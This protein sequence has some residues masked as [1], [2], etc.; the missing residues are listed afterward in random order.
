MHTR[1]INR[2]IPI[3]SR[4]GI[5]AAVLCLAA[6][7]AVAP[8]AMAETFTVDTTDDG[9]GADEVGMR[10]FRWA[11][12][13]ANDNGTGLDTI[14][15]DSSLTDEVDEDNVLQIILTSTPM[16]IESELRIEAPVI[17]VGGGDPDE[18]VFVDIVRTL[19]EDETFE[20]TENITLANASLRTTSVVVN[21]GN[22]NGGKKIDIVYEISPLTTY[23]ITFNLV[24][25]DLDHRVDG[26]ARLVK[27]GLG[28]LA[29]LPS[30]VDYGGGTLLVDGV[31]RVDTD[32]LQ[33]NIQLCADGS[34]PAGY[35][36]SQC[37]DALLIFEMP[38]VRLAGEGLENERSEDGT[39]AGDITSVDQGGNARVVKTGPGQLTLTGN[40][41]Y[42]GG[43]FIM[44]GEVVGDTDAI[45]GD[46]FICSDVDSVEKPAGAFIDCAS[47]AQLTFD[48]TTDSTFD[49]L[50]EGDGVVAK[51]GDARLTFDTAHPDFGGELR[52]DEG[53]V[54][55]DAVI[56]IDGLPTDRVDVEINN[57][58]TLS[59]AGTINGDVDVG[60][61]GTI[62]G[63]PNLM[64]DLDL[65][66]TLDLKGDDLVA[67]NA[68][69]LD[70]GVIRFDP[71]EPTPG[72]LT[73]TG[74]VTL[75]DGGSVDVAFDLEGDVDLLEG[76]FTVID[77][78][79]EIT[80]ELD[81]GEDDNG[82][83][84]E[85]AIFDLL[86]HYNDARCDT[87]G[88]DNVCLESVFSPILIDDAETENQ[89]A[90]AGA[91]DAAYSCAQDPNSPSCMIDQATADDFN[92]VYNGFAVPASE[93][94]EILDLLS[95]TEYAAFADLRIAGAARFNRSISRRFDL[96]LG[97]PGTPASEG[98]SATRSS[99]GNVAFGPVNTPPTKWMT[100]GS[101]ARNF[102]DDHQLRDYRNRR[103]SWR[104]RKEPDPASMDRNA[105]KG[106][107]TG[108]MDLHGVLGEVKGNRN[109]TDI[110][111]HFYGPLFGLDYG[112]TEILTLGIAAGYTR[113]ELKTPNTTSKGTGNTYQ[114]GGYF[115]AAIDNLYLSGAVRYAYSEI[116]T[117]RRIRF[118]NVDRIATADFKTS[119]ATGF[120]EAAYA[121]PVRS[122]MV[123]EPVLSIVYNRLHQ[124]AFDESDAGALNLEFERQSVDALR[125][126]IG[127][128]LGLFGRDSEGG[129]FAP[130][131]RAAYERDWLDQDR[132]I[133][134]NLPSAGQGGRFEAEAVSLQRDRAVVGVSSE[135]GV[136]ESAN[137]FLDYD[138]RASKDFLE[139]SLALG[140]RAIW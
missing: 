23:D 4:A 65:R 139:H 64:G 55:V 43:T 8:F 117:R 40:N 58:G 47:S 89:R 98:A 14:D 21:G 112:V 96:E 16:A 56:G 133:S 24:D 25:N 125:T 50:L 1:T 15:F 39:Y 38:G 90:I 54:I 97:R 5:T 110:D 33:E 116:E 106:G 2:C 60:S 78:E 111:Y 46:V 81:G 69:V 57:G 68:H 74:D 48:I 119:D 88:N 22:E 77:S 49:G 137:L 138:L 76:F 59:G 135:V 123:L 80:G 67:T 66:G 128:R 71:G 79:G 87:G 121:V 84:R 28:E 120:L 29:L 109:T 94:P 105:G 34:G 51:D 104:Q 12:T 75:D 129:Y 42:Q 103:F 73:T 13:Q 30:E 92:E 53:E 52:V 127:V 130:Q 83:F 26:P 11:V 131:L 7:L 70:G 27:T 18:E 31:L 3:A 20:I 62:D 132:T 113:N 41:S 37:E 99:F 118:G 63:G 45:Q 6:S 101:S 136:S 95:G 86:L 36:S 32:G 17:V 10:T 126:S 140:V 35:T 93:I 124:D 82:I 61:G 102:A 114:V 19:L 134:A 85:V 107:F 72:V 122:N 9:E 108:W 44:E 115:G 100:L 91:I